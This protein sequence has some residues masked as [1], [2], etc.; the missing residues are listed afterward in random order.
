MYILSVFLLCA[1]NDSLLLIGARES[2]KAGKNPRFYT[3]WETKKLLLF[4]FCLSGFSTPLFPYA[5]L[6][7]IY[8]S[9]CVQQHVHVITCHDFREKHS[10]FGCFMV[11]FSEK[12]RD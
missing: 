1:P 3:R 9:I 11:L 7:F 2:P 4:L 10:S 8:S 6:T 5:K 12:Q